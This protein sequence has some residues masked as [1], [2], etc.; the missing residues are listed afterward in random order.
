MKNIEE[1][2][3]YF[4]KLNLISK[5]ITQQKTGQISNLATKIDELYDTT[6]NYKNVIKNIASDHDVETKW[7]RSK[8]SFYFLP[9]VKINFNF[10]VKIEPISEE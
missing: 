3:K 7:S 10:E 5:L 9:N 2:R 6:E 4:G 1:I 8:E